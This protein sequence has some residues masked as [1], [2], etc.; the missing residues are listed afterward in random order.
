MLY[1]P[2]VC[3]LV[4]IG[5]WCPGSPLQRSGTLADKNRISVVIPAYNADLT[6]ERCL[7]SLDGQTVRPFQ[8]ILVDDCSSDG[9]PVKARARGI[10]VIS[11]SE[12]RGPAR[13]RNEGA[14]LAEGE[15]I[16][17]LDSDVVVPSDLIERISA[18]FEADPLTA[19]VQTLYSPYCPAADP[20]S[21]YQNF[22]YF[23]A[24]DRIRG[25]CTATFATWCAAIRKDTF[26]QVGGFNASIPEPTVEDE[27]LGY[28][29]ADRGGRILL[30]RDIQVTHLASYNVAQFMA[31]RLR[32]ARAQAKSG[33]RSVIDRLLRRYINIRETGTHHSRWVVLSIL[34]VLVSGAS[35]IASLAGGLLGLSLWRWL[36]PLASAGL[37]LSLVCHLNF[38]RKA[39]CYFDRGVLPGFVLLCILD[40][41]ALGWGVIV[42]TALFIMGKRY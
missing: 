11:F 6:L 7:D 15:I 20:V 8:V 22:Y 12:R 23:Y 41:A 18:L 38:F 29:I 30:A 31:R 1:F 24:L 14:G 33:W 17:F 3:A 13:A 25:N 27:E 35:I 10:K 42:G 19:A 34:L 16:L 28:E 2:T 39:A 40:M 21:R 37:L 9:T 36:L 5:T 32:M 4:I 26:L